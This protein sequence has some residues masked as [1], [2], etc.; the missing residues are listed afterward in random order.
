MGSTK[1][2]AYAAT[3]LKCLSDATCLNKG[4][5]VPWTKPIRPRNQNYKGSNER[6]AGM[7]NAITYADI[8]TPKVL[9]KVILPVLFSCRKST[10]RLKAKALLDPGAKYPKPNY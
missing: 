2:K 7:V 6:N 3:K 5:I 8:N 10:T 9:D 1:G 4:E